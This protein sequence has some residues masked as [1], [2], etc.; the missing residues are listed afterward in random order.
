[1]GYYGR[2]PGEINKDLLDKALLK[3]E[4]IT[5]RPAN[6]INEKFD[7]YKND[8][9]RYCEKLKIKDLSSNDDHI[10]TFILIP[11]GSEKIFKSLNS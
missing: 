2:L 4:S 6:L 7:S 8:L 11:Y 3:K 5:Q 9:K 1:M 10:L